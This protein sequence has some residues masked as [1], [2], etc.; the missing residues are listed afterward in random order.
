MLFPHDSRQNS[1]LLKPEK[2][3]L[4]VNAS[5][6]AGQASVASDNTVAG[7]H[8]GDGIVPHGTAD[9]LGGHMIPSCLFCKKPGNM[10]IGHRLTMGDCQKNLPDFFPKCTCA[11]PQRW[12]KTRIFSA[13]I[14]AQPAPG[15]IENRKLPLLVYG[16]QRRAKVL[17]PVKPQAD[18]RFAIACQRNPAERG[19][20][21]M[22]IIHLQDI[23]LLCIFPGVG[24]AFG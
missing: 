20:D 22:Y 2:A 11:H 12:E 4:P 14:D 10:A 16:I 24:R 9:G 13:E 3:A 7:D 1:F 21:M 18:D 5:G 23:P 19:I 6:I 17:L 8:Q 15:L